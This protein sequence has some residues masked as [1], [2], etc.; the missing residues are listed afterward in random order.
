[1]VDTKCDLNGKRHRFYKGLETKPVPGEPLNGGEL[2]AVGPH[3]NGGHN[4]MPRWCE[5]QGRCNERPMN[6]CG[7]CESAQIKGGA[8]MPAVLENS[9][10]FGKNG[11]RLLE[12][13]MVS[14]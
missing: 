10:L 12:R 14:L 4:E 1:V 7:L 8:Q 3:N 9:R 13:N 6:E 2:L 11:K 5:T